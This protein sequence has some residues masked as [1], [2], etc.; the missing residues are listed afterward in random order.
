MQLIIGCVINLFTVS[1]FLVTS[2]VTYS[3]HS[4]LKYGLQDWLPDRRCGFPQP[5]ETNAML[6]PKDGPRPLPSTPFQ[7]VI[8]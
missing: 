1:Q 7:S 5:L 4:R 3:G 2:A 8:H 6:L